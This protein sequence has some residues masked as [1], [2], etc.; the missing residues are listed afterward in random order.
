MA[1]S[2]AVLSNGTLFKHG[3][4]AS[5]E[6][7]TTIP[8]VLKLSVPGEKFDLLDI[9][10]HDNPT[11][12]RRFM[13]GFSDGGVLTAEIHWTP[14]NSVHAALQTDNHNVTLRNF[15]VVFPATPNNTAS[16]SAYVEDISPNGDVGKPLTATVRLR[17]AGA[18]TW[19]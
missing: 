11:I 12:Y 17:I 19:S 10:S 18:I 8:E 6:V 9:S 16:F 1:A 15:K 2:I 4:G 5:P 13:A 3:D 7:F 14:A